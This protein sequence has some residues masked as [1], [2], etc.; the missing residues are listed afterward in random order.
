MRT[1][2]KC[3]A[4]DFPCLILSHI[5]PHPEGILPYMWGEEMLLRGAKKNLNRSISLDAPPHC[6]VIIRSQLFG[7]ITFPYGCTCLIT[8]N[9]WRWRVHCRVFKRK[10]PCHA[11]LCICYGLSSY[12]SACWPLVSGTYLWGEIWTSLK[13]KL[14]WDGKAVLLEQGLAQRSLWR[15]KWHYGPFSLCCNYSLLPPWKQPERKC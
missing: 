9:T 2:H 3:T 4:P 6:L 1:G 5:A 10:A 7:Q 8:P 15:T 11:K 12:S 13:S 14:T